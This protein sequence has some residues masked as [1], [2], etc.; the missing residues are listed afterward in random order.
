MDIY[1]RFLPT[2]WCIDETNASS[3]AIEAGFMQGILAK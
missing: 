1:N 2:I 3:A